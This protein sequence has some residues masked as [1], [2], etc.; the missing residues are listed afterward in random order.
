MDSSFQT[1][2][3]GIVDYAGLFP[4]ASLPLDAAI[5]NYARY[6]ETPDA[7]MLGRFI[8]PAAKL[9]ELAPYHDELFAS[10]E[11]FRFSALGRSGGNVVTFLTG[12]D[13]DLAD[14]AAFRERHGDRVIV[15]AYETRLSP[16]VVASPDITD[17]TGVLS[18]VAAAFDRAGPPEISAFFEAPRTEH[19]QREF[20]G[21]IDA[22]ADHAAKHKGG[23]L[24]Q[25]G[26]KLRCG[27]VEA[28]AFPSPAQIAFVIH[29]CREANVP[30]K[31][32]AGLHHPVR[33]FNDGVSAKMHGFLNVFG[34]G[35]LSAV[36]RFGASQ[37]ADILA[38]ESPDSF[39]F[40]GDA[41]AWKELAARTPAIRK[42]RENT[43]LSFGS[44]SFDEPR[45]DLRS[46]GLL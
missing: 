16:D 36:H 1:F 34:A 39:R 33:H 26:F 18:R 29:H 23:R 30:L 3:T 10:G 35:I 40:D 43:I 42:A 41:F 25:V 21:V 20:K 7:W 14:I 6:R 9:A 45:D 38:D 13:D 22:L 4:P 27:G 11:P 31:C 8:C 19:W 5:Q 24:K 12:V 37:I 2:L 15:D 46:L 44:C 32:T 17:K 28:S